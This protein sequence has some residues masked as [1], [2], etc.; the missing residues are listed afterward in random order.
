MRPSRPAVVALASCQALSHFRT[1]SPR[2]P[3]FVFSCLLVTHLACH[4]PSS[5]VWR[6]RAGGARPPARSLFRCFSGLPFLMCAELGIVVLILISA[7]C[8]GLFR[9]SLRGSGGAVLPTCRA[10]END[11]SLSADLRC[12]HLHSRARVG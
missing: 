1:A 6:T 2:T 3:P 10:F 4:R 11:R 5:S 12:L 9:R 8:P 7:P